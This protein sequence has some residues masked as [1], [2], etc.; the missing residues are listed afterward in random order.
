MLLQQH[1]ILADSHC[2]QHHQ[3]SQENLTFISS[4][5]TNTHYSYLLLMVKA[6]VQPETQ[7][8]LSLLPI[9]LTSFSAEFI[10]CMCESVMHVSGEERLF[11]I[12]WK[13]IAFIFCSWCRNILS[14]L[15]RSNDPAREERQWPLTIVTALT[16]RRQFW[17][18]ALQK[19]V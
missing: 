7:L 19:H 14:S 17:H 16:L 5:H 11:S 4:T 15:F 13:I 8:I 18:W 2:W 1:S 9:S 10:Y 12:Q 6:T 3:F